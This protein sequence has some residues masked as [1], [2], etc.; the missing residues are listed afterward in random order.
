[1]EVEISLLLHRNNYISS[2]WK[3]IN[4]FIQI[5][6]AE[7]AG[8]RGGMKIK[9]LLV[10]N[11]TTLLVLFQSKF[12]KMK[13]FFQV[14]PVWLQQLHCSSTDTCTTAVRLYSTSALISGFRLWM[15]LQLTWV[16]SIVFTCISFISV[17]NIKIQ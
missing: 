6:N 11:N 3:E 2:V 9:G 14:E 8:L 1:M 12:P 4:K 16:L 10:C 7:L 15:H 5:P 13:T 17:F